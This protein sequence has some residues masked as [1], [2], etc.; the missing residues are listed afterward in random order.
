MI[1]FDNDGM[2]YH[3]NVSKREECY[4]IEKN[5]ISSIRMLSRDDIIQE[6]RDEILAYD[7]LIASYDNKLEQICKNRLLICESYTIENNISDVK[8]SLKKYGVVYK[9][10]TS[11]LSVES[12]IDPEYRQEIIDK[13][14][15]LNEELNDL[16]DEYR[17]LKNANSKLT[18]NDTKEMERFDLYNQLKL[19]EVNERLKLQKKLT[20]LTCNS[21]IDKA[22]VN[23]TVNLRQIDA[24]GSIKDRDINIKSGKSLALI[25]ES[26]SK[27]RPDGLPVR[28]FNPLNQRG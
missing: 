16:M 21:K 6:L 18:E 10:I 27:P 4:K 9:N 5:E 25:Q 11:E 28:F 26:D 8:K 22:R 14:N 3:E 1:R 17:E 2:L 15:N 12:E 7:N 24:S 13:I 19:N 23:E 20:S